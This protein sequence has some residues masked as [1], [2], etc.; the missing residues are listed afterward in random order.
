MALHSQT[1]A[2]F[3]AEG[4]LEAMTRAKEIESSPARLASVKRYAESRKEE[5]SRIVES[6][7]D[8]AARRFN[9]TVKNSKMFK[10]Q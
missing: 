4:D 7:P 6:L 9:G 10:E 2:D 1:E 5:F 3:R 8:S